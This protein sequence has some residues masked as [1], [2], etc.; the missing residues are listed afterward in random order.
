MFPCGHRDF[1]Q[2]QQSSRW[3]LESP[4]CD[5]LCKQPAKSSACAR[6]QTIQTAILRFRFRETEK[7]WTTRVHVFHLHFTSLH[8]KVQSLLTD[9]TRLF[10]DR[11][12][13]P[14]IPALINSTDILHQRRYC[15]RTR[16]RDQQEV[17][18]LPP[19]PTSWKLS[20]ATTCFRMHINR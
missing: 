6:P 2:M 20:T 3:G 15:N 1:L 10:E 17:T 13:V 4:A 11:A 9:Q 19:V 14:R 5:T 18:A 16:S 7:W 12:P 8:Q